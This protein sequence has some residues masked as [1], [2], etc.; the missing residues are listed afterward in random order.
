MAKVAILLLGG[1]LWKP[2]GDQR[3]SE[4]VKYDEKGPGSP[5]A[6]VVGVCM[7][8]YIYIW[9]YAQKYVERTV[10]DTDLDIAMDIGIEIK[11][12]PNFNC[13][14]RYRY[15]C[16]YRYRDRRPAPINIQQII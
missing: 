5:R 10:L 12:C 3:G 13:M 4:K 11:V 14:Y 6:E 7:Y 15:L 1:I 8:V 16:R 9:R 2:F